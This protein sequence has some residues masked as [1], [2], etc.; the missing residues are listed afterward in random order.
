[1]LLCALNAGA[2][3][4]GLTWSTG[5]SALVWRRA[6]LHTCLPPGRRAVH[7]A[8]QRCWGQAWPRAWLQRHGRP[9][10]IGA[11]SCS[12]FQAVQASGTVHVHHNAPI[13]RQCTATRDT[14]QPQWVLLH[15]VRPVATIC[16][17]RPVNH[18]KLH[19]P[20][21]P[22]EPKKTLVPTTRPFF[23]GFFMV[24]NHSRR[25]PRSFC[26]FLEAS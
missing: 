23:P 1:M 7:A 6:G 9:L 26:S 2:T 14:S 10:R 3:S 8:W 17:Q 19:P 11:P 18:P 21:Q 16:G 24:A 15:C 25:P 22:I 12:R 5:A 20:K 13:V 4:V